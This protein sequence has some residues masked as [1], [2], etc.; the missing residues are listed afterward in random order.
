[1]AEE[2]QQE[3]AIPLGYAT[4]QKPHAAIFFAKLFLPKEP[5]MVL[6]FGDF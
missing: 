5:D 1:M 2:E 3:V 6:K 4:R